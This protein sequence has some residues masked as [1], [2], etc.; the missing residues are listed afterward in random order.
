MKQPKKHHISAEALRLPCISAFAAETARARDWDDAVTLHMGEA[1]ARTWRIEMSR[2]GDH[3]LA[4]PAD[5]AAG[6]VRVDAR[7]ARAARCAVADRAAAFVHPW[8]QSV[9]MTKCGNF[10]LIG[11]ANGGIAIFNMQSGL[12]RADFGV[13]G[14]S[15]HDGAVRGIVVDAM[16][17]TVVSAGADAT[18]RFWDFRTHASRTVLKTDAPVAHIVLHQDTSLL[19]VALDSFAVCIYDIDTQR[20]VR[21]FKGHHGCITDM[22]GGVG[23]PSAGGTQA[24][25]ARRR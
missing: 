10:A 15:G 18:L 19:A 25:S 12:R 3:V 5:G 24:G 8:P 21:R 1:Y 20:C 14:Q 4:G 9:A 13:P 17:R 6:T 23:G 7:T 16:N 2:I 11:Y 22:V